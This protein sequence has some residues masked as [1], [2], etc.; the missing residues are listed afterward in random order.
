MVR[1]YTK[2][3]AATRTN[4][5]LQGEV[6]AVSIL[7]QMRAAVSGAIPGAAGEFKS[8][9]DIG[10]ALQSDGSLKLDESKL[11]AATAAGA[12]K[13]A[14]LFT[15]TASNPDTYVTRIK[16]FVDKTQGTDGLIPSKTDGLSTTIKRLDKEQA[17][18]NARMVGV[19]ARLRQQ[20]NALDANLASQNA[21]TAYLTSQATAWDN[22]RK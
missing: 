2:Y 18:F 21:V 1:G 16:S 7:N 19:E 4:G 22:A 15:A 17:D 6:T 12:G 3:D 10:I 5:M 9:S 14:R 13:L 8:L 11:T 20:F